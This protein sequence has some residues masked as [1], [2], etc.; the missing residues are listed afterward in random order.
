MCLFKDSIVNFVYKNPSLAGL[1][2]QRSAGLLWPPSKSTEKSG[3]TVQRGGGA[4]ELSFMGG[5][6]QRRR[7]PDPRRLPS[8]LPDGRSDVSRGSEA[9]RVNAT[10]QTR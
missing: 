9:V 6:R 10:P 8:H 2:C 5:K 3:K 4:Q 7:G 1:A